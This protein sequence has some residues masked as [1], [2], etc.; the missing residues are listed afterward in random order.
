M[1]ISRQNIESNYENGPLKIRHQYTGIL[2][3]TFKLKILPNEL[4][5]D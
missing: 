5:K 2:I 1:S 4:A 3:H